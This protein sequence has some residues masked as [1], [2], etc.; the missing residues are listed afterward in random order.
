RTA[1]AAHALGLYD[2]SSLSGLSEVLTGKADVENCL[3]QCAESNLSFLPAGQSVENP[4]ELL[5]SPRL[6]Q[7]MRD[8][9]LL[10][11]WVIV[12]SAPVLP[13][14][15]TNLLLPLFDSALLVVRAESTAASVVKECIGKVGRDRI[16][17]VVL[18]CVRDVKATHYYS[19]YY[20][21]LVETQK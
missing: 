15:D 7:V 4:T 16:S 21:R 18:N 5:S 19:H 2:R 3:L 12:D 6:Q 10:F 8:L 20:N 17:G 14:A 1:S 9:M 13:L 11:D